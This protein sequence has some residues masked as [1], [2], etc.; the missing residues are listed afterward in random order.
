MNQEF[1]D[2]KYNSSEF[3]Y[4]REPNVF[5]KSIIDELPSGRILLLGEG[6]GR[7]AV[8][9]ASRGWHVDA[10]DSSKKAQEKALLFATEK[11]VKIN[12]SVENILLNNFRNDNYNLAGLLFVHLEK[13][14]RR[15]LSIKIWENLRIGGRLIM[16]V[17]SKDQ[18]NYNSGG[19]KDLDLLYSLD[20]IKEDFSCFKV[21]KLEQVEYFIKEGKGHNGLAN[22]I[23]F[24]GAK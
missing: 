11:N 2:E 10:F 18:I 7:N 20:E 24:I 3:I 6:E 23:R 5:F 16:E 8:Y 9:A 13:K 15:K 21:D 19:P 22:V 12:Y 1:W 17:F 4:G 14:Q